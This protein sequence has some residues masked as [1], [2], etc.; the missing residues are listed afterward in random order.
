MRDFVYFA[1]TVQTRQIGHLMAI[2]LR[3]GEAQL[4]REGLLQDRKIAIFAEDQGQN[5]PVVARANSPIASMKPLK[6]FGFPG[7][8]IGRRP[9]LRRILTMESRRAMTHIER[10]DGLTARNRTSSFTHG[11]A[12]HH[13]GV[14]GNKIACGEFVFG[15][16]FRRERKGLLR[17]IQRGATR[18]IAKRH[19][20]IVARI[21]LQQLSGHDVCGGA[22]DYRKSESDTNATTFLPVNR[23][24]LN[25]TD[26]KRQMIYIGGHAP[27]IISL[28]DSDSETVSLSSVSK[29]AP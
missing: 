23:S 2:N 20:H 12:V 1:F 29:H 17:E 8:H 27:N 10:G 26:S 11:N 13:D 22:S 4:F 24:M 9:R 25:P 19:Q 15:G 16:N 3:S 7:A 18:E 28:S 5:D 21:D 14:A 6:S